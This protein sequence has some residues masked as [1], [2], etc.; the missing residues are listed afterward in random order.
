MNPNQNPPDERMVVMASAN[1][2]Q[3]ALHVSCGTKLPWLSHAWRSELIPYKT[4]FKR[5]QK[6]GDAEE[7]EQV[8]A[9]IYM[10]SSLS[11]QQMVDSLLGR[12]G[13]E[14]T[15]SIANRSNRTSYDRNRLCED[16]QNMTG[17]SVDGKRFGWILR[18][19]GASAQ[20]IGNN[21]GWKTKHEFDDEYGEDSG[22][23][24]WEIALRHRTPGESEWKAWYGEYWEAH[25]NAFNGSNTRATASSS[26][27]SSSNTSSSNTSNSSSNS[28]SSITPLEAADVMLQRFLSSSSSS[29]SIS[30]T[31]VASPQ[32]AAGLLQQFSSSSSAIKSKQTKK[33]LSSKKTSSVNK[34]KYKRSH[35]SSSSSL[36]S[37]ISVETTGESALQKAKK[38]L[39]PKNATN[40]VRVDTN[41]VSFIK[42]TK[43]NGARSG[44]VFKSG[45]SGVGYYR[46]K[47][48][49][50]NL[51]PHL[52]GFGNGC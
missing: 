24:L 2:S 19:R 8:S 13:T 9:D 21:S 32:E 18:E 5:L 47:H 6:I 33:N 49:D 50:N 29:S 45:N 51:G 31:N 15:L 12:G 1:S 44:Y 43:F 52:S 46:D 17:L 7:H 22:R 26:S 41:A 16:M 20:N 42:A 38:T 35:S 40:V 25:F 14:Y 37:S 27:S 30:S 39:I 11:N 23:I 3:N 34:G 48:H 28:T 10:L 36:S 4:I